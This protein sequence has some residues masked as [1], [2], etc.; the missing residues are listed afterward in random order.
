VKETRHLP[1]NYGIATSAARRRSHR[2]FPVPLLSDATLRAHLGDPSTIVDY[3]ARPGV[4]RTGHFRLLSGRH[5]DRFVAFS[6]LVDDPQALK[7]ISTWLASVVAPWTP[8]VVLAPST[9]GVALGSALGRHLG[10]PLHLASLD[11]SG[12]PNGV[13]G[14]P[15]L[16]GE[17]VLLVNDIVT[18][19]D[20]ISALAALSRHA[21]ATVAGGAWFLSRADVPVGDRIDAPTAAVGL[22]DLGSHAANDC[23]GCRAEQPLQ[24]A[25]D[26][27]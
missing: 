24:D 6:R 1:M 20:G 7:T 19:G 21:G 4:L 22:L 16:H 12:R 10:A 25:L 23:P 2:G 8:T 27:N 14:A 18:T 5:A 17:S 15:D 13:L 26:L 3:L 11:D 9:A